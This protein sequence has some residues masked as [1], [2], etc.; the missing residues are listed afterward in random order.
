MTAVRALSLTLVTTFW[1]SSVL[2]GAYILAYYGGAIADR[3]LVDW[4]AV[5][6]RLYEA[7]TPAASVA[8]GLHFGAGAVIL[9]LGCLQLV[10]TIRDRWP[11][12]H[13]AGGRI[14]VVMSLLAGVGGLAFILVKGTVGGLVMD[15]GFGLYGLLMIICALQ[16]YRF[17]RARQI[18][19]HRAWALRLFALAVGSW[20][21]RM[22][23]GFWFVLADGV[24]HTEDFRGPFDMIM[25]FFFYLPN[26]LLV[27]LYLRGGLPRATTAGRALAVG[28]LAAAIGVLLLGTYFFTT[29]LWGPAILERLS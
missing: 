8:I 11:L 23:Y 17:A 5:L 26:L 3:D 7:S 24:G 16:A 29:D 28:G 4:N 20:L 6:P 12:V 21:Y 1:I 18:D 19:T 15:L 9:V 27:E 13:R 14:Y 22:D 25:S 2:F 10:G